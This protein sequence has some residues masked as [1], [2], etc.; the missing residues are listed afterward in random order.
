MHHISHTIID[1]L[2]LQT[3]YSA[4]LVGIVF[5]ITIIFRLKSPISHLAL[6]SLVL[7]RLVLPPNVSHPL[8]LR[9]LSQHFFHLEKA[10]ADVSQLHFSDE[11]SSLPAPVP[12]HLENSLSISWQKV[13]VVTWISGVFISL[14]L[15]LLRRYRWK[16]MATSSSVSLNDTIIALVNEWRLRF[17]I[18][19]KVILK[20]SSQAQTPFTLGVW[21]P[22]I[23]LPKNIL[24]ST[25]SRRSDSDCGDLPIKKLHFG[26]RSSRGLSAVRDDSYKYLEAIIAHEMAHIKRLDDLWIF[27]QN[28]IQAFYFFHPAVWL[29]NHHIYVARECVCDSMVLAHGTLSTTVYGRG[30]ITYLKST[31][32]GLDGAGVLAAFSSPQK[33]IKTRISNMK[34]GHTMKSPLILKIVFVALAIV[35]LP[36]AGQSK[37]P[38]DVSTPLQTADETITFTNPLATGTYK[39][40]STYGERKHPITGKMA[41]HRAV[42]LAAKEGTPVHAAAAGAITKVVNDATDGGAM[43]KY[44]EVQHHNGF[45]TRYTQLYEVSVE[46]GQSVKQGE[47]IGAVGSSGQSTGPHLHFEIWKNGDHVNPADYINF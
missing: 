42:D 38:A 17:G 10:E 4:F 31:F 39:L 5:S 35:I 20:I 15:F 18:K 41:F 24:N 6:W 22:V 47:S 30:L 32:W 44:I 40:T 46:E 12:S 14:L 16:R 13:L 45:M 25:S 26:K 36:M 43:G 2:L 19:R 8:S 1:A 29:T 23:V 11:S 33:V 3:L 7:I 37:Q 34:K 21:R 27:A 28:I 9:N